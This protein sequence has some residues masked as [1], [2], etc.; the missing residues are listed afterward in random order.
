MKNKE[1]ISFVVY[2]DTSLARAKAWLNNFKRTEG[3]DVEIV[4]RPYKENRSQQQNKLMWKWLG[5]IGLEL[6]STAH[7]L[8]IA[9]KRKYLKPILKRDD[10]NFRDIIDNLNKAYKAGLEV[11]ARELNESVNQLMSTSMLNVEQ[12]GEYLELIERHALEF[13]IKLTEPDPRKRT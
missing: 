12:M 2:N 13:G 3:V 10:A 9:M 4:V 1:G 11:I 8:H 6:G 5:E 7:E